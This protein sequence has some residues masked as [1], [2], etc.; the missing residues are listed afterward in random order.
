MKIDLQV[1]NKLPKTN[2]SSYLDKI[3]I[4]V[5]IFMRITGSTV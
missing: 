3:F 1:A 5:K 2:P 4:K